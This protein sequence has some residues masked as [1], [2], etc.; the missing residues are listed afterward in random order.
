MIGIGIPMTQARMPFILSL[1]NCFACL[2]NASGGRPVPRCGWGPREIPQSGYPAG[3]I[4]QYQRAVSPHVPGLAQLVMADFRSRRAASRVARQ[5]RIVVSWPGMMAPEGGRKA[6]FPGS[7][8][9]PVS[10]NLR[11]RT[12]G[13][14]RS[15]RARTVA[16]LRSNAAQMWHSRPIVPGGG[17]T[18][19][20]KR[21]E[22]GTAVALLRRDAETSRRNQHVRQGRGAPCG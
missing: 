18:R 21:Q 10:L 19:L 13:R 9:T 6:V 2:A 22:I 20:R 16:P 11:I 4:R 1:Q 14:R 17:R 12:A 3:I 7:L 8:S 15:A 5:R